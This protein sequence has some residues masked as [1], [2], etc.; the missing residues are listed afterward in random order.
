MEWIKKKI[1]AAI[2]DRYMH[3]CSNY[4]DLAVRRSCRSKEQ[5]RVKFAE[6]N[7]PHARGLVFFNP[8]K[9]HRF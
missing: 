8:W 2:S 7:V 9:A 5:G 4:N 3:G 1:Y 6:G